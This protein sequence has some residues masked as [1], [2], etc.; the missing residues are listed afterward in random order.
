MFLAVLDE[1]YSDRRAAYMTINKNSQRI[2][3]PNTQQLTIKSSTRDSIWQNTNQQNLV[4]KYPSW[5]MLTDTKLMN[6]FR[7]L[8]QYRSV[9]QHQ[10]SIDFSLN[11]FVSTVDNTETMI[12]LL[13]ELTRSVGLNLIFGEDQS[14][15]SDAAVCKAFGLA[16]PI[17][18]FSE[19]EQNRTMMSAKFTF[20]LDMPYNEVSATDDSKKQFVLQFVNEVAETLGCPSTYVR[21]VQVSS[22]SV[23]VTFA[24]NASDN[25]RTQ[26]FANN[27]RR[28]A[29]EGFRNAEQG[30][31]L[32]RTR[33]QDYSYEMT[34]IPRP[35]LITPGDLQTDF[36]RDYRKWPPNEAIERRGNSDYFLPI[37]WYRH[38]LNVWKKYDE[39][40]SSWLDMCGD[41][42][43]WPVAYH[44]TKY[45]F[46]QQI[47]RQGLKPGERDVYHAEAVAEKSDQANVEAVYLATHCSGNGGAESFADEFSLANSSED[48]SR[49]QHYQVVLQCRVKPGSFTEHARNDQPNLKWLRVFE[50]DAIRPYGILVRRVQRLDCHSRLEDDMSYRRNRRSIRRN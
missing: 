13:Q 26:E 31:L 40:D 8:V 32:A 30:V 41:G 7:T 49:K 35:L 24:L 12:V 42:K 46:V 6:Q 17:S 4:V 23:K 20:I 39:R 22:G 27:L 36:N 47:I 44:G 29:Q 2:P 37:G 50:K 33:R 9:I 16:E 5:L 38:A 19:L 11:P 3:G 21:I 45:N 25:I 10:T 18:F 15:R 34:L 28:Q 43:D 48:D 1:S 14:I